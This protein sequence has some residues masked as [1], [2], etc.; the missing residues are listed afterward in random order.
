MVSLRFCAGGSPYDI[1]PLFGIGYNSVYNCLWDTIKAINRCPGMK[2]EFP[3][4][5]A[6]QKRIAR[7][8]ERKNKAGFAVCIGCIDGMLI[9]TE[10]PTEKECEKMKCGPKRFMCGRKGKYGLNLQAVCD[11]NGKFIGLFILHPGASSDLLSFIRSSLYKNLSTPGFLYPGLALFG[12][13]AYV[14]NSFIVVPYKKAAAGRK[15]D[16]NFFHSS[17]RINIE[18]AFGQLVCRW[19]I[20]QKA[21]SS[22]FTVAK[23]IALVFALCKLHNFAKDCRNTEQDMDNEILRFDATTTSRTDELRMVNDGA[24]N[25]D[26]LGCPIGLLDGGHHFDDVGESQLH[27]HTIQQTD[28]RQNLYKIICDNPSL[29]RPTTTTQTRRTKWR[30]NA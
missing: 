10:Q 29:R 9:W 13:L 19:P 11:S 25:L 16:F 8:F 21:L 15:D 24:I 17:V 5:H 1:F 22:K 23:Q 26:D 4:S 20:L 27:E 2:V 3:S 14:N 12:D 30:N 7:G 28:V 18:C 6:E